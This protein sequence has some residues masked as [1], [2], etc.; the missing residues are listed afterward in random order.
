MEPMPV[1]TYTVHHAKSQL[2][3]LIEAAERGEEVVIARG[4]KPAV[5][6]V[7]VTRPKIIVGL[8]KHLTPP[9]DGIFDADPADADLWEGNDKSSDPEYP[10]GTTHR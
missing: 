4:N 7:P 1:T 3:K 10:H 8:W 6:L 5:R 2:S 9:P